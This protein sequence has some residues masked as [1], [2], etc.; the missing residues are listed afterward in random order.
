MK[1]NYLTLNSTQKAAFNDYYEFI[2]APNGLLA[3]A[4]SYN[5]TTYHPFDKPFQAIV[6]CD[7]KKITLRISVKAMTL[8]QDHS[9]REKNSLTDIQNAINEVI[10]GNL[11]LTD[12][13]IIARLEK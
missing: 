5:R 13:N 4:K 1:G 2:E 10:V 11:E 7:N 9:I 3:K 8:W 6:T 12:E